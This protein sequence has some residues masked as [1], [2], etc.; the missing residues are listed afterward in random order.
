[1]NGGGDRGRATCHN[2]IIAPPRVHSKYESNDGYF[3]TRMCVCVF[4][5]VFA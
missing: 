1:M 2:R 4:V 5:F 3:G